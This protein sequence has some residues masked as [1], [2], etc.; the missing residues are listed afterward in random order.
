MKENFYQKKKK[1]EENNVSSYNESIQM[2][3]K[4]REPD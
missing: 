4:E 3:E 2:K 1:L